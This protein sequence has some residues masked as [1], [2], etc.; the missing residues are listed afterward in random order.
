MKR[1][2]G[3]DVGDRRIGVAISDELGIAARGLFTLER[4]NTKSD[5]QK[6]LDVVKENE[7]SA[8]VVGLPL[9]LSGQ[10]S[11]QTEKV[12]AFAQKLEN[13]FASNAMG[14]VPVVLYDE[15]FTTRIAERE[16]EA[17]GASRRQRK[18]AVDRQA[19]VLILEDWMRARAV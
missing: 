17:A 10:D 5:T 8:V 13:K 19:A 15:R 18:E 14:G 1:V 6:I 16:L 3:L 9:N 7:C 11:V 4:T 12:R 2:L